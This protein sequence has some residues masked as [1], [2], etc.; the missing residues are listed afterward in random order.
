[1]AQFGSALGLRPR[2]KFKSLLNQFYG[3]MDGKADSPES[4]LSHAR[5]AA[6]SEADIASLREKLA[7]KRTVP[8][9]ER[10]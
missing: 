6:Q 5:I 1:M 8:I 3:G 4:H 7:S 10:H 9:C 2:L